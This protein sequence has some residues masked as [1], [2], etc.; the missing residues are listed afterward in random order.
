MCMSSSSFP[1]P[2]FFLR[3][4]QIPDMLALWRFFEAIFELVDHSLSVIEL[5]ISTTAPSPPRE[6]DSFPVTTSLPLATPTHLDRAAVTRSRYTPSETSDLRSC[7]P[8]GRYCSHSMLKTQTS[9]KAPLERSVSTQSS[10]VRWSAGAS[11]GMPEKNHHHISRQH[12]QR[13]RG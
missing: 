13:Q 7:F 12:H 6:G 4:L 5:G 3:S 8:G 11:Q 2:S 10:T 1:P 9:Y